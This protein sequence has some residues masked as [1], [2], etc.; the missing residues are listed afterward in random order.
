MPVE[1]SFTFITTL[2]P[3][4]LI[5]SGGFPAADLRHSLTVHRLNLPPRLYA[6]KLIYDLKAA[7]HA[8]EEWLIISPRSG[9][10][11]IKPPRPISAARATK[12]PSPF[13]CD[14]KEGKHTYARAD[15]GH[16]NISLALITHDNQMMPGLALTLERN[17]WQCTTTTTSVVRKLIQRGPKTSNPLSPAEGRVHQRRPRWLWTDSRPGDGYQGRLPIINDQQKY[18]KK[19]ITQHTGSA[20]LGCGGRR[21]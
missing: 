17:G 14:I 7:Y 16:V 8:R 19:Y 4:L 10:E 21:W 13:A 2:R 6:F 3:S 11:S 15:T 18:R 1:P 5:F 9:Q 12:G 20:K